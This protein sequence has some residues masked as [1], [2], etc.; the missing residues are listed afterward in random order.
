M[1]IH[2][3]HK[4]VRFVADDRHVVVYRDVADLFLEMENLVHEVKDFFREVENL[5]HHLEYPSHGQVVGNPSLGEVDP[6]REEEVDP[7][8]D[9]DGVDPSHDKEG[10]DPSHDNVVVDPSL[11]NVDP[12]VKAVNRHVEALL[13][14][15]MNFYRIGCVPI[16]HRG[17]LEVVGGLYNSSSNMMEDFSTKGAGDIPS[18]AEEVFPTGDVVC[19]IP[20]HLAEEACC[21]RKMMKVTLCPYKLLLVHYY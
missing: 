10:V 5:V 18:K 15:S 9:E 11:A 17:D 12:M 3:Y 13:C 2:Y 14:H 16:G 20:V 4:V 6:S 1:Q 21:F 8:H 19:H 7:S